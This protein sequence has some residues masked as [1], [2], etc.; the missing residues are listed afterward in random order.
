MQI[1]KNDAPCLEWALFYASKGW[2]VFP[3]H[4]RTKDEYYHYPEYP[5]PDNG[6]EYSWKYQAS[7]DPERVRKFWTDHPDASI[8][9][10]TGQR[11]G[12]LYVVDTDLSKPGKAAGEPHFRAWLKSHHAENDADTATSVTGS[13]GRQFFFHS[14]EPVKGNAA[15]VFKGYGVD[16]RGDGGFVVLPPSIHPNGKK[17]AWLP[18]FDPEQTPVIDMSEAV[19][20]YYRGD[21]GERA[22]EDDRPRERF[23]LPESIGE[24]S[25][26]DT[27]VK[28]IGS[29]LGRNPKLGED[30]IKV[31]VGYVNDTA[32]TPSL[33]ERELQREVFPSIHRFKISG[34]FAEDLPP[35]E[36]EEKTPEEYQAGTVSSF[37][38][39]F[40]T[41]AK[42]HPEPIPTGW[43]KVDKILGGGLYPGLY[44]LGSFSSFGKTTFAEQLAVHL[45]ETGHDVL[46]FSLEMARYELIARGISRMT[47]CLECGKRG[48]ETVAA[49]AG[50]LD[51][52]GNPRLK[53]PKSTVELINPQTFM[54]LNGYDQELVNE[55]AALYEA[56]A[57][58]MW[59]IE[60]EV[61]DRKG[62]SHRVSVNIINQKVEDHKARTGAYPVVFVDYLQIIAGSDQ[63]TDKANIDDIV[64]RLRKMSRGRYPIIAI[65]SFNRGGYNTEASMESFKESGSIE[66]SAD[67]LLALEPRN[68]SN[69]T[70]DTAT[71]K[72]KDALKETTNQE[73]WPV[74][75]TFLKNRLGR[76][77]IAVNFDYTPKYNVYEEVEIAEYVAKGKGTKEAKTTKYGA[78]TD[79]LKELTAAVRENTAARLA[80]GSVEKPSPVDLDPESSMSKITITPMHDQDPKVDLDDF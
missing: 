58:H 59:V 34:D 61:E 39:S 35:L 1:P 73:T 12:G 76:R 51:S 24:G 42:N 11:S 33:S 18:L 17:Y 45:S 6:S 13:G 21:K 26:T 57:S 5:N 2:E 23:M 56:R 43:D 22:A 63:K 49:V 19:K 66:Y 60:G 3:I 67:V 65:S 69:N 41:D 9:C 38:R 79:E 27:L 46:F 50:K 47:A 14:T 40:M 75:L 8:G 36:E 4:P 74:K 77:D 32:C 31:L 71:A 78:L 62:D 64:T 7:K 28:Y 68:L 44:V 52:K 37:V 55:A 53:G 54:H 16:T 15:G 80:G 10:A 29:L 48:F 70:T 25:R 30:E 20:L 72:N